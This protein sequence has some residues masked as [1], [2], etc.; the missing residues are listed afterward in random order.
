MKKLKVLLIALFVICV[1]G[2]SQV[3]IGAKAGINIA[4]ISGDGT[5]GVDPR[6]SVHIGGYSNLAFSKKLS[7]QPELLFNAIGFTNSGYGAMVTGKLNYISVPVTLNYSIGKFSF[8]AGPQFGILASAKW[9]VQAGGDTIERNVKKYYKGT[10][11][12]LAVGLGLSFDR[13]DAA[14]RYVAGL[15]NT[16]DDPDGGGDELRNNVFQLSLGYRIFDSGN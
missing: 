12:G 2:Y 11:V 14:V 9:K 16:F 3:T 5:E 15:V 1:S 13:Y 8:H 10:D 4:N 7:L 6:V